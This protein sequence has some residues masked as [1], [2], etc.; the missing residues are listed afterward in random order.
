MQYTIAPD[1]FKT[2]LHVTQ[3]LRAGRPGFDSRQGQNIF[4]FSTAPKPALDP[5]HSPIEW[6]RKAL[7][8]GLK[9]P[10]READNSPSSADVKIGGAI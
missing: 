8:P 2:D 9:R 1:P 10:G 3:L 4:L 6:V 7:S 5:T